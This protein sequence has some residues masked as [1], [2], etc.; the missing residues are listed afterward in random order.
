MVAQLQPSLLEQEAYTVLGQEKL[1]EAFR[2]FRRAAQ[3]YKDQ[4]NHKQASLCFA[5]AGSCWARKSGE[6]TFV[7]A[8]YA[9]EDAAR[10]AYKARD[11]VYASRMYKFA[12]INYERDGE[13]L[14]FADCYYRSK[15]CFRSFLTASLFTPHTV[16]TSTTKTEFKGVS[17]FIKRLF[18]CAVLTFSYLIWGHGERPVRTLTCG[19]FIVCVSAWLY[20]FGFLMHE[21]VHIVPTLLEAFYYS[22]ITFTTVGYGDFTPIG[23]N[24]L[25]AAIEAFSA[26]FLV[27]VYIIGLS[28]KYLR[29]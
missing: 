16:D 2:L 19:V 3:A 6:K 24:K 13:S 12:A 27:P 28:R 21:G 8:A 11:L 10:Q 26:I 5:S 23:V 18:L 17:G 14:A 29:V 20:T 7:N 25:I 22:V 4:G 9:Y 1:E 15:E